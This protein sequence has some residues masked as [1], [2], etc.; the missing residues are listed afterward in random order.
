M[1]LV[2]D[3]RKLNEAVIPDTSI[4]PT[5]ARVMTQVNPASTWF[6]AV[7][8]LSSYHQVAKKE[9]DKQYFAFMIDEGKQGGVF[10]YTVAPMGFCN[11]GHSFVTNLSLLL[12]DLDVLS[13]VDDLLMEGQTEDEVL[14][15][16]EELLIRCRKFNIKISR[17]K[18]QFGENVRFAGMTVG[19]RKRVQT[20]SRKMS[21]HNQ[22]G[23]TF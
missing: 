6:V 10:V 5:P 2:T 4:F 21:G 1:G 16:F 7:D 17:W 22:H 14:K 3:L 18:I 13:E 8:L 15:K 23:L 20:V 19:G 12:A 11:S 9:E